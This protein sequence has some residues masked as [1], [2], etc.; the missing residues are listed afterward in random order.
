V[1]GLDPRPA[2]HEVDPTRIYGAKL[3]NSNVT[4]KYWKN[5]EQIQIEV[6]S[7]ESVEGIK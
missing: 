2:F 6:L 4:W 1:L 7:I 5:D 3:S